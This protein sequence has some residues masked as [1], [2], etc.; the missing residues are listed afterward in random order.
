MMETHFKIEGLYGADC[1]CKH[2]TKLIFWNTVLVDKVYS[3]F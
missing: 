1:F 2:E 3:F